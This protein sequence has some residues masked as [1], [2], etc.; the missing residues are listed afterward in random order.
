MDPTAGSVNA[1]MDPNNLGAY[2]DYRLFKVFDSNIFF[3]DDE[4]KGIKVWS[5]EKAKTVF[6]FNNLD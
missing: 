4:T 3:I 5:I 1:L 6:T 2:E